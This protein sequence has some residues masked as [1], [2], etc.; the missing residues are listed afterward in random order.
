[1][2]GVPERNEAPEYYYTYIDQ[3]PAGDILRTLRTQGQDAL[4]LLQGIS[5][6][7]SLFRYAPDKWSIREVL[8]HLT[9]TERVFAFRSLWFARELAGALPSFDQNIAIA[10]ACANERA[11]V[12]HVEEFRAIRAATLTL[13]EHLPGQAWMRRG[14]PSGGS[15]TVRAMAYITV[16]HVTHHISILRERYLPAG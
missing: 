13:F 8:S 3:V 5:D 1:V 6:E 9:D 15:F 7:G 4:S 11:W 14:V 10:G 16:G 12:T 2:I